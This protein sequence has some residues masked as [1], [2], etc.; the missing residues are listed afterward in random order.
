MAT[1]RERYIE[2]HRFIARVISVGTDMDEHDL[3]DE[4]IAAVEVLCENHEY[5]AKSLEGEIALLSQVH[6]NL[7]IPEEGKP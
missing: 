1:D 2:A 5:E 6:S 7:K 4:V 3:S